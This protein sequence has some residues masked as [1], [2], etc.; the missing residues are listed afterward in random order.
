MFVCCC[1]GTADPTCP[2]P[3]G[4]LGCN[5]TAVVCTCTNKKVSCEF[6]G[7]KLKCSY[8][9]KACPELDCTAPTAGLKTAICVK[10][11]DK[12]N[13]ATKGK[14]ILS[15][16]KVGGPACTGKIMCTPPDTGVSAGEGK[17]ETDPPKGATTVGSSVGDT[18]PKDPAG[19]CNE[20]CHDSLATSYSHSLT[21]SD[22]LCLTHCLHL[23]ADCTTRRTNERT[24]GHSCKIVQM[25]IKNVKNVQKRDRNFKKTFV[26]VIKNV[27]CS[28]WPI[29][30]AIRA[31]FQ[32]D[33][34]QHATWLFV[35]SHTR[36][37]RANIW[38]MSCIQ[39]IQI[40]FV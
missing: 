37:I 17:T 10:A 15:A 6:A 27:T 9:N 11:G 28:Y 21:Q 4:E 32:H 40:K 18:N 33:T 22:R 1:L 35:R 38:S 20:S 7:G 25:K 3:K 16:V 31:R 29:T 14:F 12:A 23:P 24:T 13:A 36:S 5:C 2:G 26:N 30:I 8:S 19:A 39:D 34:L